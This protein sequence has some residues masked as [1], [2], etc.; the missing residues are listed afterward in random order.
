MEQP[1]VLSTAIGKLPL[2]RRSASP[3]ADEAFWYDATQSVPSP[4][5]AFVIGKSNRKRITSALLL[6]AQTGVW[7]MRRSV[8]EAGLLELNVPLVS[9]EVHDSSGLV[10]DDWVLLHVEATV[11]VDRAASKFDER[12]QPALLAWSESPAVEL[13]RLAEHPLVLCASRR[14]FEHLHRLSKKTIVEATP[15]YS[16]RQAAYVAVTF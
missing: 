1:V 15:P 8:F 6:S 13:F 10:D 3:A 4:L 11:P 14:R 5:F 9:I 7:V 12:Q 16:V 2:V